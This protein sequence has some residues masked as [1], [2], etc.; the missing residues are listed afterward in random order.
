[1]RSSGLRQRFAKWGSV[2]IG[3]A[4]IVAGLFTTT[5]VVAASAATMTQL[6]P[7]EGA[8][9]TGSAFTDQLEVSGASGT[10]SFVQT[11]GSA[12]SVSQSGV[13]TAPG[14]LATG[15]YLA[16]GNDSDTSGDNG[17][18]T[19][20]L[21]V[22]Q[23]APS[24]FSGTV[25]NVY[26][27]MYSVAQE[28]G[29]TSSLQSVSQYQQGV[30]QLNTD[31]MASFYYAT[32]QNPEWYQ[33]PALMQT[34]ASDVSGTN[35]KAS[36]H[37]LV[38]LANAGSTKAKPSRGTN[39]ATISN[40]PTGPPVAPFQPQDCPAGIPDAALFALQIAVD[41]SQGVYNVL[42][43]TA[44]AFADAVDAQVGIGFAAVVSG[45]VLGALVIVHDVLV[46]EQQLAD[47]CAANNLAG[48]VSNIDNTTT[49]S[50]SLITTLASAVTQLQTTTNSS[51]QDL[52]NLTTQLTSF[53]T[54][55]MQTI[56]SDQTTLQTAIGSVTQGLTAQLQT[57]VTALTQDTTALGADVT[58]I[59]STVINQVN[60]DSA[61][62]GSALSADL[63]QILN[64][65]DTDAK[66][67]T[68][69]VTQ[70]N[71]QVLNTLQSNFTT[72]QNEY[73]ANLLLEIQR[74]LWGTSPPIVQLMVPA[75]MGGYLN[76]TPVG[77]QSV[78]TNALNIMV[79]LGAKVSPNAA[80]DLTA[81]NAALAAGKYLTAYA[82]YALCYQAFA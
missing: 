41:V 69:L 29:Q 38:G 23:P 47:D 75:T 74:S 8:T 1:M 73:E 43:A 71:Q 39:K 19:Y 64:E 62:L 18:W 67:L 30:S 81:A 79:T 40:D 51:Q 42:L 3:T 78:V 5:S 21:N 26:S 50:Y 77:V 70:D 46:F 20:T 7:L 28:L 44:V 16:A 53:Q 49:Q 60:A 2:G 4:M 63:T 31:Q 34:V 33:I 45:V 65:T 66:G 10:V 25:V 82:D 17:T 13:V 59:S 56:A 55:L 72:Q 24:G 32:Q 9:L 80:K 11:S 36:G 57:D 52:E 76:S 35:L 61:T 48:Y 58:T 27:S 6:T 12:I 22:L 14:S 68:T 37:S 54:T 15:S